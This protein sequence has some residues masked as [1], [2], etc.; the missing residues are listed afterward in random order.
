[1]KTKSE[2]RW[3]I[4]NTALSDEYKNLADEII[5]RAVL[6][7]TEYKNAKSVFVYLSTA[8][9][10]NT[11]NIINAC[12]RDGKQ[13]FVPLCIE[14]N[15]YTAKIFPYTI[16]KSNLYGIKEPVSNFEIATY[17]PDLIIIPCMA[18]AKNCKRLGH[19]GGYYDKYLATS[20][21]YKICLCYDMFLYDD[22]PTDALDIIMDKIISNSIFKT[23][24]VKK[25]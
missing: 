10:P 3:L 23:E 4:R 5:T 18:A 20:K 19:G 12:F 9:E 22:L 16:Y 14:K 2:L 7:S 21:G 6:E 15:M 13:V 11:G 8:R 24:F 25:L 17:E 1:M